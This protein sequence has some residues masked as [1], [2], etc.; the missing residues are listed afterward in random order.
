MTA[1]GGGRIGIG[2][3]ALGIM[4]GAIDETLKYVNGKKTGRQNHRSNTRIHSSSWLKWLQRAEAAK[5][6]VYGEQHKKDLHGQP[7]S[8]LS[9]MCKMFA[10]SKLQT[11]VTRRCLQL[12][13]GY[14]YT[15]DYPVE[16][17]MRDAKITEI[18]EGTY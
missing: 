10:C 4:Q 14:G 11:I 7:Y 17:V 12:F 2:A 15:R 5:L 8:H 6:M 3:Q 1:L 18:Y 9:A 13:G 16:R